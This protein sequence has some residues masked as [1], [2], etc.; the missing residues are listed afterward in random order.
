MSENGNPE[1][2]SVLPVICALLATFNTFLSAWPESNWSHAAIMAFV[3]TGLW[4]TVILE[5]AKQ[6]ARTEQQKTDSG[7]DDVALNPRF[8]FCFEAAFALAYTIFTVIWAFVVG[9]WWIALAILPALY[10]Y[11]TY[12]YWQEIRS[13]SQ[14]HD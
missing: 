1:E 2:P 12:K 10:W 5:R 4:S 3:A 6:R 14:H 7:S 8:K 11:Y 9:L 13:S